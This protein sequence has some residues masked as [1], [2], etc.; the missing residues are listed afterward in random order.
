MKWVFQLIGKSKLKTS[1]QFGANTHENHFHAQ[2]VYRK[3]FLRRV[4]H[5]LKQHSSKYSFQRIIALPR[6]IKSKNKPFIA[7]QQPPITAQWP[8]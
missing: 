2:F 4:H 8:R 5:L 7:A 1:S 6:S 3:P